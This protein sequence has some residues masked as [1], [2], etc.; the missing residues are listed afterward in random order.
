MAS[1]YA[2]MPASTKFNSIWCA[3]VGRTDNFAVVASAIP[4]KWC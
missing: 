1:T 3:F 4:D 2:F